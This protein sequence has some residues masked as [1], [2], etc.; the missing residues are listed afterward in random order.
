MDMY[1]R[2][3]TFG[4]GFSSTQTRVLFA[5]FKT[6]LAFD[7]LNVSYNQQVVRL[8]DLDGDAG[9]TYLVT[10]HAMG[11]A[12]VNKTIG[13]RAANN[14]FYERYSDPCRA[15]ENTL[16]METTTG[17]D[18]KVGSGGLYGGRLRLTMTGVLAQGVNV[19]VSSMDPVIR[20][21]MGLMFISLDWD[22]ASGSQ[23]AARDSV[24]QAA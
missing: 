23:Q 18:S 7:S 12:N 6:G 16:L 19:G 5:G 22:E 15:S 20:Q 21:G 24:T 3:T 13:P 10:G 14:A 2:R 9:N 11:Q 8:W 4:G 1:Q 17:C